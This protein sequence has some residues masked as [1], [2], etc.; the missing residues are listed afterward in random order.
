[1]YVVKSPLSDASLKT[2]SEALRGALVDLVDLALVAK[3]IHWNVVGPRFRSVHLQL[4]E[5]VATARTHSDT[6][7]ERAAALG[8]PPDG[9]AATVAVG[10]GIG[11]TPEGWIDDSTAVAA[12]VDALGA[13][14]GRMRERIAATGDPDPVTQDLF[15]QVTADLEKQHWMF[16]AENG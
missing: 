5:V 15:I 10:S 3:Q 7:A 11:A 14:I 13:V 4:D 1:M 9:R 12:I 16:Q 2:V 6:V 8:V